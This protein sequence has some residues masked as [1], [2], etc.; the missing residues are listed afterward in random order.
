DVLEVVKWFNNHGK[1]LDRLCT[2]QM[3]IF[4]VVL[5][6]LLPVM[7]CWT[8]HYCCLWQVKKLERSFTACVVMHEEVLKFCA[9]RKEEQIA[10]AE[11]VFAMCNQPSS[12][13][14]IG[15]IDQHLEPLAIAVNVLQAPDCRRDTVLLTLANLFRIFSNLGLEDT[16]V[17]KTIA[18]DSS[19]IFNPYLCARCFKRDVLPANKM[20][21]LVQHA[22]QRLLGQDATG[23]MNVLNVFLTCLGN[24]TMKLAIFPATQSDFIPQKKTVDLIWIWRQLEG[25]SCTGRSGFINLAIRILSILPNSVGA[26]RVFSV[27]GLTHTKHCNSLK[28]QKVHDT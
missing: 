5:R 16:I 9:G 3:M 20:L 26:E 27:F 10:A 1:A 24:T 7:T 14:N 21:H 6:L 15:R 13:I 17:K 2:Q 11:F 28:L 22:F 23:D 12:W 18:Y 19:G 8:I 25:K 4:T